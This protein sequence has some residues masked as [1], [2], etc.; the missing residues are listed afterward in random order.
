MV[1]KRETPHADRLLEDEI[2]RVIRSLPSNPIGSQDYVKTVDTLT[3]LYALRTD[4]KS[5]KLSKDTLA[6]IGANLVGIFMILKHERF[7]P[8]TSRAMQFVVK[9]K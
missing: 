7:H 4:Q 3:K 2:E 9:A 5:S 8:I 6:T 1:T